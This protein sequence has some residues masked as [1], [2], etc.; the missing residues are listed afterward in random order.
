MIIRNGRLEVESNATAIRITIA[1]KDVIAG[2]TQKGIRYGVIEP[3]FSYNNKIRIVLFTASVQFV[4]FV[5]KLSGIE[6]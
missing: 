6:V 2:H 1:A 3:G 5:L 4:D